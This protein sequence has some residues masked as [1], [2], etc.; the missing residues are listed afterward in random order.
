MRTICLA[1]ALAGLVQAGDFHTGQAARAV[2]GQ[3]SFSAHEMGISANALSLTGGK[4]YAAESN[5]ILAF[6]VSN[7]CAVC[8]LAPVSVVNQSVMRGVSAVAVS[9]KV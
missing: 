4:L 2:I 9:G 8:G 1:L 6:D 3:T 7:P 5:R